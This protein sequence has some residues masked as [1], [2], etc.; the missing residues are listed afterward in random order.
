MAK[1][2]NSSTDRT[3]RIWAVLR[4]LIGLVFLWAFMDKMFGLG[5]ATCRV[6]D[7]QTKEETV[8]VMCAKSTIKGGSATTGFLKFAAKGP[9]KDVFN[10]LAGNKLVDFVFMA[11]LGLIGLSLVTG[12]GVQI[13]AVSGILMLMLMWL[14]LIPGENNPILDD[15][16]IYSV[17]LL[18]VMMTNKNQVCGFGKWWQKQSIVKKHPILA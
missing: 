6:V 10:E 5:F 12:I 7:A 4:I 2:S 3:A 13:A 17:A 1:K 15:H 8:Q 14:A 16:I 9:I 11:G 18:G